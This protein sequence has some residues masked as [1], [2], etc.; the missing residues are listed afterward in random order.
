MHALFSVLHNGFAG[1]HLKTFGGS[2]SH[3]DLH[4]KIA[5]DFDPE[6]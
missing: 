6:P 1:M 4:A 2:L 3:Q 5:T